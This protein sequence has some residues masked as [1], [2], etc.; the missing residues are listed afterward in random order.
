MEEVE[1]LIE[2]LKT[3]KQELGTFTALSRD[4]GIPTRTLD[5]WFSGARRPSEDSVA[6]IKKYLGYREEA[7]VEVAAE[8]EPQIDDT[9]RTEAQERTEKMKYLLVLLYFELKWFSDAPKEARDI[10]RENIS[11]ED[12]GYLGSL[13]TMLGKEDFFQ[14]WKKFTT[15]EFNKF[16]KGGKNEKDRGKGE[17]S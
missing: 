4:S 8:R 9:V 11:L 12:V 7:V 1:K 14:R 17:H 10:F 16:R 13:L 5:Y 3:R 2:A 15:A 6:R